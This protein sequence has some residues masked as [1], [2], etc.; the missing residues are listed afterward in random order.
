MQAPRWYQRCATR[1]E[2]V[3]QSIA[4]LRDVLSKFSANGATEQ[5]L[6]D[7]KTYLTGSFPL[8]FASNAG[9]AEQLGT[10]QRL[11]LGPEYVER[12]NDL[13]EAVTL[14]D[15]RRVAKRLFKP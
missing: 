7:A 13:I 14:D 9:I 6:A 5:E 8:A 2:S 12:R 10:F 11:G 1:R 15:I 4:V 3:R